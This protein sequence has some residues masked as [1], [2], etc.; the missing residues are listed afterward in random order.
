MVDVRRHT[1]K[2]CE[3]KNGPIRFYKSFNG[4]KGRLWGGGRGSIVK[5]GVRE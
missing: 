1:A 3:V 4:V 2:K 5:G